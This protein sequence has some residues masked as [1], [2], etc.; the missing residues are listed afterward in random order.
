[1]AGGHAW[2]EACMAGGHAWQ[3]GVRG[4]KNGNC[5]GWY[6]SY[7]NAFLFIAIFLHEGGK[8]LGDSY[9]DK[10]WFSLISSCLKLT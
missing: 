10:L 6:A 3:G 8:S 4:R 5:S 2:W 9:I 1:M 7:W